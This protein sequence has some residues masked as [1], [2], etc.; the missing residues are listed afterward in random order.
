MKKY[1]ITMGTNA[2]CPKRAEITDAIRNAAEKGEKL[3]AKVV[4]SP[5]KNVMGQFPV[6]LDIVKDENQIAIVKEVTD[7]GA[8]LSDDDIAILANSEYT[9]EFIEVSD[10]G[11]T[12]KA[13]LT[14]TK[15]KKVLEKNAKCPESVAKIAAE[16]VSEGIITK[17]EADKKIAVMVKNYVDEQLMLDVV[18]GWRLYKK[19]V[20]GLRCEYVDPYL[21]DKRKAGKQGV[22]ADGL[23]NAVNR[24]PVIMEGEKS[25]G[26]NV[27]VETI[28]WLMN[29][30]LFLLTFSRNMSPSSV[31]GEKSTD[32]SAAEYFKTEIAQYA[33]EARQKLSEAEKALEEVKKTYIST[34]KCNV[35]ESDSAYLSEMA[36]LTNEC[37]SNGD[38]TPLLI[39]GGKVEIARRLGKLEENTALKDATKSL[40]L[41]IKDMKE[42]IAALDLKS[43]QAQSV[44]III[45]QSELYDW[46]ESGG[47]M[48][49]NEMNM[50]EPNFFASFTNQLCDGTG[51]LFIP[52]RGEV[53]IHKDCVLCGTQNAD[54]EGVEQQNEATMSR[55]G[56][57]SF[58]QP[59][60]IAP[61][62]EVAVTTE[63]KAKGYTQV[64]DKADVKSVEKFYIQC[65]KA[66]G[67]GDFTNAVLNIRG[68]VRALTVKTSSNG[69][70]SLA[71]AVEMHVI[72]T[73]PVDER[74]PLKSTA[75]TVFG[76]F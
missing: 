19:P 18:N 17:D 47:L 20:H 66:V 48:V 65:R 30:P 68:F 22:I 24:Y 28:A 15:E 23:R 43:A 37:V 26:K 35:N 71:D 6:C 69:N 1:E 41:K 38:F 29:M 21:S 70:L 7:G 4:I 36:N 8:K 64:L 10:D 67:K 44:N 13:T 9:C 74:Q 16:K 49:F 39:E 2:M 57:I 73:C 32:N 11:K 58:E 53:P 12:I 62:L 76:G 45:D 5:E 60:T 54:Y 63:L 75:S 27:F 34:V 33:A 14:L 61:Q 72:N 56:C 59:K 40:E 42:K 50:A 46:L 51:F 52:G 3:S 55:F 31:Y 25:V